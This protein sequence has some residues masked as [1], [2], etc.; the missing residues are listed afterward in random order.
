M[1]KLLTIL[2]LSFTGIATFA[3]QDVQFSMNMFNRLA[4][5]PGYAGTN[6]AL[7]ATLFYRQQWTSF[8]GAPKTGLLSVDFGQVA[9]GGFGLTIDR[10]ELGFDKTLKAKV[11]YSFHQPLGQGLLGIGID[12]GMIQKRLQ[13]NFIAPDGTTSATGGPDNAIPWGGT[14]ATTYDVGLGLYYSTRQL[15]VGISALH[16][17]EQTLS[18]KDGAATNPLSYDFDF[19]V[20]RHYYIMAGY[21]FDLT[22]EWQLTPSTLIKSDASSTQLDA[23]VMVKWSQTVFAGVSYRL[24]DAI[25][26]M[27]GFERALNTKSNVRL[28]Y[29]YDITTSN[30]K[31]HSNGSHEIVLGYCYKIIKPPVKQSH[32]NVRF[33]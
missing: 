12:A 22:P 30:I 26:A 25:V 8:P 7:C 20:A 27:V 2:A 3:Q 28:G 29:S 10:D 14:A 5:N 31:N 16:L 19:K 4:I 17:P 9:R 24:T 18:K 23:N 32:M 1:K 15:Y 33:L 6:K 13:G 21:T 11:A